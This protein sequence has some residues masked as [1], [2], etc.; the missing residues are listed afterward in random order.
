MEVRALLGGAPPPLCAVGEAA[1]RQL[2]QL[3]RSRGA[4]LGGVEGS[5]DPQSPSLL[6]PMAQPPARPLRPLVAQLASACVPWGLACGS[7]TACVTAQKRVFFSCLL[8]IFANVRLRRTFVGGSPRAP[9][10]NVL[11][12]RGARE[13]TAPKVARVPPSQKYS[14]R[15][16]N[17]LPTK[18]NLTPIA[19]WPTPKS[20]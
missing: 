19:L 14:R 9:L 1:L 2:R 8:V 12:Y 5:A 10:A 11:F 3:V 6:T 4:H 15:A 17:N 20:T 7:E 18:N 16:R 13:K